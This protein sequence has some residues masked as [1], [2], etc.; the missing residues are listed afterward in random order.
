MLWQRFQV[1]R[2]WKCDW[3]RSIA[4]LSIKN[5]AKTQKKRHH[6]ISNKC[7]VLPFNWIAAAHEQNGSDRWYFYWFIGINILR[8][9]L[10]LRCRNAEFIFSLLF[11]RCHHN[12]RTVHKSHQKIVYHFSF[13]WKSTCNDP[14]ISIWCNVSAMC[15]A[16]Q[17][18]WWQQ[19]YATIRMLNMWRRRGKH[20]PDEDL[21]SA[22]KTENNTKRKKKSD[23]PAKRPAECR[24]SLITFYTVDG[25]CCFKERNQE[26]QCDEYSFCLHISS[27]SFVSIVADVLPIE[28]RWTS[29]PNEWKCP[30][31]V[32]SLSLIFS[33]F[34]IDQS[35]DIGY[36]F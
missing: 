26:N 23:G 20:K 25:P 24:L 7:S 13:L 30:A 22:R 2:H 34:S 18:R 11:F 33:V 12:V 27:N 6:R 35:V 32:V 1:E 16:W 14:T 28:H 29:K 31:G 5:R 9:L 36:D 15:I 4:P 3:F 8:F 17:F 21:L 19:Q 10:H